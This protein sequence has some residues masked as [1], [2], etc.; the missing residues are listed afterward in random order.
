VNDC[1][2]FVFHFSPTG[3][4][5]LDRLALGVQYQDESNVTRWRAAGGG[6]RCRGNTW[7]LPYDT[8][9][10]RDKDRPHP[11]TF[12]PRLPEYCLRLHGLERVRRVADPFT[13]LGSTAVACATLGV[14]FVG[15]ELDE[16]YLKDAV[17]RTKAA[18]EARV[19]RGVRRR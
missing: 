3:R 13:G 10:N 8:I 7:F 9:Q 6:R 4:T 2:E 14:D 18:L 15:I 12:P 17:E 11:A 1:H 5:P 16:N 19:S